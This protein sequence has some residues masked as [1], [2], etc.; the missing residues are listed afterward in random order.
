MLFHMKNKKFRFIG[1]LNVKFKSYTL[2]V[3]YDS[4]ICGFVLTKLVVF[5]NFSLHYDVITISY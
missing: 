2:N 5:T 4:K 3:N 1:I